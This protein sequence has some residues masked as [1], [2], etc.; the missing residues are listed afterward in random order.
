MAQ[1]NSYASKQ[2]H[3]P[4][5]LPNN[6]PLQCLLKTLPFLIDLDYLL[7]LLHLVCYNIIY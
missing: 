2:F 4:I 3:P 1:Q 5:F 6:L 7:L